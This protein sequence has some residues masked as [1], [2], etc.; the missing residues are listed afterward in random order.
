MGSLFFAEHRQRCPPFSILLLPIQPTLIIPC[1]PTPTFAPPIFLHQNRAA[2]D[3]THR[4]LNDTCR[5][6]DL[7]H[8]RQFGFDSFD[9]HQLHFGQS[10]KL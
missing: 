10:T 2:P 7:R 5:R 8:L 4:P 1:Y 3:K 9:M 6:F